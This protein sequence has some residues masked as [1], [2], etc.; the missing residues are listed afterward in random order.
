MLARRVLKV[1]S[2]GLEGSRRAD[3]YLRH[4][5][6][7]MVNAMTKRCSHEGFSKFPYMG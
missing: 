7:D 6:E 1:P 2:Y 5:L 4:A 3:F